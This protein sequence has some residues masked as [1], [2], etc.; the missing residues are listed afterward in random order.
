MATYNGE[1]YIK[2]QLVSILSQLEENDEVIVSDDHSTD[3]TLD[4][5]KELNDSRVKVFLN[6]NKNGLIYNFENAIK[7]A[8]GSYIFLSDQDD[9]WLPN[10][11]ALSLKGL[12]DN[13]VVVTNCMI[14]NNNLNIIN[15]S[16]F[17][18]NN[19]R[20]GFLKNFYKTSYLGCCTAFRKELLSDILPFPANL[21]VY[22]DFWIGYIAEIKYKVQFIETPCL[23]YRRH[24]DNASPTGSKSQQSLYKKLRSR[25]QLFYLANLRLLKLK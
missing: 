1:K 2:E 3:K 5:V 18:F 14:T 24:N 21:Y 12:E 13:D 8:K 25:F 11:I 20:K 7:Q 9:V 15:D 22:H 16:Y 19:S 23:L 6:E 10:K 4:I 17:K